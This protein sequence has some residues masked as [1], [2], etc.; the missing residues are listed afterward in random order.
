MGKGGRRDPRNNHQER[1]MLEHKDP[2]LQDLRGSRA[3]LDTEVRARVV[4][5][6]KADFNRIHPA[7]LM[8]LQHQ[9]ETISQS[10]TSQ[11]LLQIFLRESLQLLV[12]IMLAQIL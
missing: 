11:L 4:L 3:L 9:E 5:I 8:S 2:C 10:V 1:V 6:A 7:I 12:K